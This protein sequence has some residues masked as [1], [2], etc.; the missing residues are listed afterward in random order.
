MALGND[1]IGQVEMR[2]AELGEGGHHSRSC[3]STEESGGD[4]N[5]PP[6]PPLPLTRSLI[7]QNKSVGSEPPHCKADGSVRGPFMLRCHLSDAL[8]TGRREDLS[9]RVGQGTLGRA[10]VLVWVCPSP[11]GTPSSLT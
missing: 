5:V 10:A 3:S 6:G 11:T 1:L 9:C 2:Q 8:P 7:T 4:E